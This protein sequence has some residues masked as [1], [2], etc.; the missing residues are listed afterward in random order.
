MIKAILIP[1]MSL[2]ETY[3]RFYMVSTAEKRLMTIGNN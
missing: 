2:V 1:A 3:V